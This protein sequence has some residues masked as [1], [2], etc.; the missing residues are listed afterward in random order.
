MELDLTKKEYAVLYLALCRT[1]ELRPGVVKVLNAKSGAH[2]MMCPE[3]GVDNFQ[4]VMGCGVA[5]EIK[6]V[7][8]VDEIASV[9]VSFKCLGCGMEAELPAGAARVCP[10]C[11]EEEGV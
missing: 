1:P 5:E 6:R 7:A 4:H 3:C 2:L 11:F 9:N 10:A 8:P